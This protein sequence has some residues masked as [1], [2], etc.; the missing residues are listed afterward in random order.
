[1]GDKISLTAA[2]GFTFDTWLAKPEGQPKGAVMVI[3]EAFGVNQHIREVAEGFAR[4]GYL[5]MAPSLYD[6]QKKDV[7]LGY[8]PDALKEAVG[9][10]G[11][12]KPEQT[13]LDL[14]TCLNALAG[15]GPVGVV[16]YCLG[17]AL[18]WTAACSLDQVAC[19]S[20]YY[21]GG[22]P[23]QLDRTPR[24]PTI[25]HFGEK[26]GYIPMDKVAAVR[27]A[28]PDVPVYVYPAGHGFNCDHRADFHQESADL[29]RKR[30]L[31]L[32]AQHIG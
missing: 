29:A 24:V 3:Q 30:T 21:G 4:Q 11:R 16:G 27:E 18:A 10:M 20:G 26:D 15:T 31:E 17:G 12:M 25:L 19:A 23:A 13:R 6:R 9:Y 28:A 1:M 22:I 2:D 8:D 7:E 5:T 14:Q 32:F